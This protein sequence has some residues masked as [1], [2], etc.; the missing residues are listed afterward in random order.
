MTTPI[1]AG[2]RY[3]QLLNRRVAKPRSLQLRLARMV[4]SLAAG[5]VRVRTRLR[6][7]ARGRA[8]KSSGTQQK[9]C[10]NREPVQVWEESRNHDSEMFRPQE[11]FGAVQGC[12]LASFRR[13][14]SRSSAL[15]KT[16][17]N[18]GRLGFISRTP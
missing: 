5:L 17:Y 18:R 6:P 3:F 2:A 14:S 11:A 16:M 15:A 8:P 13:R 10:A 1:A 12:I 4:L 9:R 7:S